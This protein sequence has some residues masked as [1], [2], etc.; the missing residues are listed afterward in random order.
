MARAR[1]LQSDFGGY[2]EAGDFQWISLDFDARGG[3][4]SLLRSSYLDI[5]CDFTM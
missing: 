2:D 5:I 3:L 1:G 4:V